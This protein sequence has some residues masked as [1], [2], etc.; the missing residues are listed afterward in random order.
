MSDSTSI[1]AD[2][3]LVR[4]LQRGDLKALGELYELYSNRVF[5]TALAITRDSASAEDILQETFLRLYAYAD[6]IDTSLPL[7]PWI[8][9]ITVNLSYSWHIWC[10]RH[11][12]MVDKVIR[13][14]TPPRPRTE[15]VV[16]QNELIAMVRE[17]IDQLDFD[18]RVVV[19]LY[20][21][22]DLSVNEIA[23]VLECPVGTVKSRLYYARV[24]LRERLGG[25][26]RLADVA[27]GFT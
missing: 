2:A 16:E 11:R 9:R 4:R 1:E 22:N 5:H 25:Q 17:A 10:K 3:H 23:E 15:A 7:G 19:V 20:Y 6:H 21:L 13:M 27:R 14:M 8:Y 24:A 26:E 12:L 18:Q